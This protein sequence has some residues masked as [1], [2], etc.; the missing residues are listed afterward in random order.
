MK[1]EIEVDLNY[2]ELRKL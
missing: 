1:T 2:L